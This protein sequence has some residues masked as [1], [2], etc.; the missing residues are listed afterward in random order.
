VK[1][2]DK[3][4]IMKENKAKYVKTEKD[5]SCLARG[6]VIDAR[7]RCADITLS[8]V[9]NACRHPLIVRLF[10]TMQDEQKLCKPLLR[11]RKTC[12]QR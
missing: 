9:F 2:L 7:S 12:Q 5:V 1:I 6:Y 4:H 8:Q 3:A 10:Y 11:P